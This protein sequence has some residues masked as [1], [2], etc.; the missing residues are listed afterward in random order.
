MPGTEVIRE[1]EA[2]ISHPAAR[3]MQHKS[4]HGAS[5]DKDESSVVS[6]EEAGG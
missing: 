5:T 1:R 2:A 3:G 4:E 6:R